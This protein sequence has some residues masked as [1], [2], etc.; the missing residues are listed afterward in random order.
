MSKI[1]PTF[2]IRKKNSTD[3]KARVSA[4]INYTVKKGNNKRVYFSMKDLTTG[5][6][7]IIPVA[8]W[9][10]SKHCCDIKGDKHEKAYYQSINNQI[11]EIDIA[12]KQIVDDCESKHCSISASILSE[13]SIYNKIKH[14]ESFTE[15]IEP[16]KNQ[17][18]VNYWSSF[19]ERAKRNEVNYNGKPYGNR[20]IVGINKCLNSFKSF[21]TTKNHHYTFDEIDVSVYDDY[22][23]YLSNQ[24]KMLN[25]IGERIKAI[26][27]IM[28]RALRENLHQNA[29]F[30]NYAAPQEE[31][32][33]TYLTEEELTKLYNYSFTADKEY[34]E[35]YRDIFLVGCYTG[36]RWSDYKSIKKENITVSPKGN[37]ILVVRTTKTGTLVH[38]P[39]IWKELR[40]ILE[41][42]GYNLPKVSEPKF[43]KYI[44]TACQYAGINAPVVITSGK[45]KR[46]APYEKWELVSSHTARRTACTNMYLKGIPAFQIMMI[47]GHRREETFMKYIKVSKEENADIVAERYADKY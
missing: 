25:T 45:H 26:K 6:P 32:D 38:I 37:Q 11:K 41:K 31:V 2:A 16:T 14:I 42:Y 3:T 30:N 17:L 19:I 1:K 43:N 23:S 40:I 10:P 47:S 7:F 46:Q 36:L 33:N 22:V 39:F 5:K 21:E 18:L 27:S 12:V 35:K 20:T 9:N 15:S 13:E 44:K 8:I 4:I 24:G 34:L 28:N 29:L